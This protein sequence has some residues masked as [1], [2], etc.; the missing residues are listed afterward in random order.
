M[1]EA[2]TSRG[3]SDWKQGNNRLEDEAAEAVDV[4]TEAVEVATMVEVTGALLPTEVQQLY[5]KIILMA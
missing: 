2:E 5:S 3:I 4:V 1:S